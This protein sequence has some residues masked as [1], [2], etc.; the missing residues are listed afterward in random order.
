MLKSKEWDEVG[1]N[2]ITPFLNRH[3]DLVAKCSSQMDKKHLKMRDHTIIT[4]HFNKIRVLRAKHSI[5]PGKTYNADVKGFRQ[6]ISESAKDIIRW[7][8][9]MT[10]KVTTDRK[11]EMNTVIECAS[12]EA[13]VLPPM[14][15]YHSAGHY[16][17]LY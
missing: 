11:R 15:I 16:M 5:L 17:G 13:R 8:E 7:R 12:G 6:G 2:C 10:A 9:S 1:K 3:A 14:I 4:D